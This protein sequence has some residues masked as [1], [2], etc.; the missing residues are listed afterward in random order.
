[1][2]TLLLI[3]ITTSAFVGNL[4]PNAKLTFNFRELPNRLAGMV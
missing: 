3:L 1:M 4:K 2:K